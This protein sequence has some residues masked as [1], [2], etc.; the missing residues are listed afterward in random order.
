MCW[1]RL[2]LK[3]P[4]SNKFHWEILAQST[5]VSLASIQDCYKDKMVSDNIHSVLN[6]LKK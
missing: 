4:P 1:M 6:L 2:N 3:M 5:T